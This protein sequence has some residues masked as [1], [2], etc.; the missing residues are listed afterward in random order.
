MENQAGGAGALRP[1]R[2][3]MPPRGIFLSLPHLRTVEWL[4]AL[5][6]LHYLCSW[7]CLFHSSITICSEF[8][9]QHSFKGSPGTVCLFRA[10]VPV[11]AQLVEEDS[12][13]FYISVFSNAM[14]HVV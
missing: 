4:P 13:C 11:A 2:P 9:G 8:L 10:Y 5:S 7:E 6:S 1:A 3:L 12:E 14:I